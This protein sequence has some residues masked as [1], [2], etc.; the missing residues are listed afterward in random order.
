MYSVAES[1][2]TW[3]GELSIQPFWRDAQRDLNIWST[4]YHR[5]TGHNLLSTDALPQFV[6]KGMPRLEEKIF[7]MVNAGRIGELYPA[8]SRV[9]RL[10]DLVRVRISTCYLDGVAFLANRLS[11]NIES[12]GIT[13]D[14]R[15]EPRL[16]GYYA[17]H[18][19][20]D[21]D[22]LFHFGT[23]SKETVRCEVQIATELSTTIWDRT[24]GAYALTRTVSS[25]DTAWQW[26]PTDERFIA[27]Q[28]AHMIHLA[29]GL[30]LQL[31]DAVQRKNRKP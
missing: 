10:K 4:E 31:R 26:D 11:R 25:A 8:G 5:K 13:V 21:V 29:D 14:E 27:A 30:V 18:L 2:A 24:H 17:T 28:L 23:E 15:T 22:R 1:A 6:G 7:E 19:Y 9:P 20:F 16:T 3:A 12:H